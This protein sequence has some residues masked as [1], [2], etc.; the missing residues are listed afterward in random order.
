MNFTILFVS[1]PLDPGAAD[2]LYADEYRSARE[3]G[4]DVGLIHYEELLHGGSPARAVKRIRERSEPTAALYRGWM[5]RP[6]QYARLYKALLERNL[7]LINAPEQYRHAHYLPES[8]SRIEG[9]TPRSVWI[10]LR[11]PPD[12][13]EAERLAVEAVRVFGGGPIIVKDYVKS[14]KHEWEEACYVPDASDSERVKRTVRRF[15][16]LQG[17]ELNE[18]LVFRAFEKL[19][20]VSRHPQSGMPL[21][22]EV[23]VFV[24]D[25]EPAFVSNYWEAGGDEDFDKA[26]D[27]FRET[28][29]GIDSRFYTMDF[30]KKENGP[31]I[32]L[33]LGDGQTAGL[34]D[35]T[36]PPQFY[37]ALRKA[38]ERSDNA[39]PSD[40][41]GEQQRRFEDERR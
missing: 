3:A 32:V 1:S 25:G 19:E 36:E 37:A 9:D 8:Y 21:S 20:Y 6:G 22:R 39:H 28:M 13:E 14:R 26:L 29:K 31:W 34:P 24:L 11:Y 18:G 41:P 7:R 27:G 40:D 4:F 16:E 33:E 38:L 15:L 23:R 10:P 30:A 12:S 2:E 5:L 35:E 17:D